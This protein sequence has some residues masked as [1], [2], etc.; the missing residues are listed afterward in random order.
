MA[1]GCASTSSAEPAQESQEW[2]QSEPAAEQDGPVEEAMEEVASIGEAE[3]APA[4]PE[5]PAG[6]SAAD[7]LLPTLTL[8]QKVGQLFMPVVWG[9]DATTVTDLEGRR[10]EEVFGFRTPAEI[11]A[12]YDL[13]GVM[14]LGHNIVAANQVGDLS[15]GLQEVALAD[16]GVGLLVAVDQ[17][18]GRVNRITDGVNV[19]P[20]AAILSGDRL[21]VEEA[22]YLTGNQVSGQGVNVVL[23]PVADLAEPGTSGA[24]GNRSYGSD[25]AVV[26]DMVTAAIDG[27]QGSGVAAAVKHWPGHGPTEVDSHIRLPVLGIG[28]DEWEQRERFPFEAAIDSDVAIVLV[29]HLVL[30]AID[31]TSA[32]ATVSPVLIDEQLRSVLGFD[33]VVMTD[34]L[35]MGAV[36][37]LDPG[38]LVI[39]SV[40]AGADVML[41]PPDLPTAHAALLEAVQAGELDEARLDQAVLRVL[42][43]K[44]SLGLLPG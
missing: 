19:F 38:Q 14:Y 40:A 8:E 29:G 18:G 37:D 30:P 39:E 28:Q 36:S 32:P 5:E 24:I 4:P 23:A 12:A 43:L 13:G 3:T 35:N 9:S 31:P 1:A 17:E 20:P 22:G 11:V 34:A 41:Y 10:N 44:E 7:E 33:G 2:L 27:L 42:R 21:A 16:S 6:P 15:A 26:A 25:P